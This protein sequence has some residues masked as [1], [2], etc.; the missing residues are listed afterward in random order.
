MI[1]GRRVAFSWNMTLLRTLV[2]IRNGNYTDVGFPCT[3]AASEAHN[4]RVWRT[5]HNRGMLG[6]EAMHAI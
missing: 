4:H 2:G 3:K 1:L 6:V 5:A